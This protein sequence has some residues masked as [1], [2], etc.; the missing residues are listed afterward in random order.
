MKLVNVRNVSHKRELEAQ[1]FSFQ[2]T[3]SLSQ[4]SEILHHIAVDRLTRLQS[5]LR[6]GQVGKDI[7]SIQIRQTHR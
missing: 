3:V 2:R 1:L 4:D 7:G 6:I 5:D